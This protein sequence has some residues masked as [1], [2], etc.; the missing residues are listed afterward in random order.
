MIHGVDTIIFDFDGTLADTFS[1]RVEAWK[2]ALAEVDLKYTEADLVRILGS[3]RENEK[4]FPALTGFQPEP[5]IIEKVVAHKRSLRFEYISR[6]QLFDD[7]RDTLQTLHNHKFQ[8]GI[9]SGN[10]SR[11][12]NDVLVR[13][14][15]AYLFEGHLYGEE[16][17]GGLFKPDAGVLR[18]V[19]GRMNVPTNRTV[20]VGD[21]AADELCA[22]AAGMRYVGV[23][24]DGS[25]NHGMTNGIIIQSLHELA[26]ILDH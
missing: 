7:V 18:F 20:M 19:M 11:V 10:S 4:V 23:V 2:A 24:R 22:Q 17:Y 16:D 26:A 3:G 21:T 5:E 8:L 9:C 15:L 25:E 6:V 13:E 1:L 14:Q 12:V